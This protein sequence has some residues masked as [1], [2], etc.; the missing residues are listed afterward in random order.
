MTPRDRRVLVRGG[1]AVVAAVLMLRV[2]PW[3]VRSVTVLRAR[4]LE[5]QTTLARA[6][7]VLARESEI[8]DSLTHVLGRIVALAPRLVEGH[9]GA[10][11]QASLS[12]LVSMAA[13]REQLKVV[14][15]DPL[16]DSAAGPFSRVALHAELEGDIAGITRLLR[17]VETGDPLLTVSSLSIQA[18]QPAARA[19]ALRIEVDVAGLYLARA[20]R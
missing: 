1:A 2:L 15:L 10:E 12:G 6:E 19:E 3:S 17:T 8:H 20:G 5:Q 13:V 7:A 4:V 14:R 18:P 9:S 16:P 11:A